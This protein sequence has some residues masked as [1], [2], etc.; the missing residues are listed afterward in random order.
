MVL[1]I[2]GVERAVSERANR[3]ILTRPVLRRRV[4]RCLQTQARIALRSFHR[5]SRRGSCRREVTVAAAEGQADGAGDYVA[6]VQSFLV[7]GPVCVAQ[8]DLASAIGEIGHEKFHAVASPSAH[9]LVAVGVHAEALALRV[10]ERCPEDIEFRA[11]EVVS[12]FGGL[13]KLHG[14]GD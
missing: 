8:E 13:V 4:M 3:N 5:C 10:G 14:Q 12:S 9:G 6:S 1:A 11:A 2:E 7:V